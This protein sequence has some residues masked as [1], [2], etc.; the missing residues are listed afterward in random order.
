MNSYRISHYKSADHEKTEESFS[1]E[2]IN[3]RLNALKRGDI[4]FVEQQRGK[5]N[6]LPAKKT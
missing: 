5:I 6:R 3:E 2:K 4:S 1:K